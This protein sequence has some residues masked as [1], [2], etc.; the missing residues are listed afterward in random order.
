MI[1]TLLRKTMIFNFQKKIH[2]FRSMATNSKLYKDQ[3]FH[4]L[5]LQNSTSRQEICRLSE[6]RTVFRS[7][8][9]NTFLY[10]VVRLHKKYNEIERS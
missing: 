9:E 8:P 2:Q 4:S 6:L 1:M 7:N 3:P 5:S 10:P